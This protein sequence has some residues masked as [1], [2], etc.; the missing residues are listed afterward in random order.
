MTPIPDLTSLISSLP[1]H[2]GVYQFINSDSEIIYIGKAKNLRKRVSSYF[3]KKK[4]DS[5][6][7]KVLVRQIA[8]IKYI[9]VNSESDALLLENN[10]IKKHQP[11]Y[12]ILLKDDKTFPW[13]CIKKESFPRVFSTR[14]LVNDGSKYY[15][16]YTSA[17]AVK[18]LLDLVR[19]LY[20]LRNCKYD[21]SAENI[22]KG[23]M[24]V[25]LEYHIGN[26]KAP[27]IGKQEE[28]DYNFQIE[29][30]RNIIKGNLNEV[31]SFLKKEMKVHA[32]MHRFEEANIF[33]EKIE[34]LSRYQAK[35]T[36]VSTSIHNVEVYSIVSEEKHAFV[37]YF[38]VVKGAIIQAHT[39]EL[40][41]KLD[42]SDE[43][44]LAFAITDMRT[45]TESES[46]ELI[47]PMDL[48]AVLGDVKISV[49]IK[50]DK[51]KLLDLSLRNA[52]QYRL[53][54]KKR[55]AEKA[56]TGS[57]SRILNTL[58]TDL[59]LSSYP[60]QIECFDNSNMQGSHPVAA[61]VVFRNARP[62]KRDYRHYHIKSVSGIDDFASMK[63][64][65]YRRYKRLLEEKQNLPQLI[66][67]DGGKGQLSAALKALEELGLRK[68]IAIIGI[69]KKLEEIYFPDD[70]VP[71]YI[72]KNSES[73]KLIQ[74]LRNEAHRFGIAFH[75]QLRSKDM[76]SSALQNIEGIGSRSIEK[77][78]ARFKSMDGMKKASKEELIEELGRAKA[79]ILQDYLGKNT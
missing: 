29:Q 35:S 65:V 6:K 69:A 37:N 4:Y 10:L 45:R 13:I 20:K 71:L 77:L 58:K 15:G 38:K 46:R 18:I 57:G 30:I 41:K 74:N 26:C 54:K 40:K 50:G 49:P 78:Y 33:K 76:T 75:R 56:K 61:C 5:Y 43:D 53:E 23:K 25:C 34:V 32:D 42:E 27:C 79:K 55:N 36:I 44:L 48:G 12:N 66:V 1:H 52:R 68:Q 63:E 8:D 47:L 24:R 17:Y 3:N 31:I 72:D 21:L 28:E 64:V 14:V 9:V 11:K 19:K 39:L 16:P 60:A 73:L 2:P 51:K 67:V 7:S 70:P 62:A 59:R 22:E